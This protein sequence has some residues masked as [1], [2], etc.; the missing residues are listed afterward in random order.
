VIE[1]RTITVLP[2]QLEFLTHPARELVYS[3]S[4]ASGK[5]RCCCMKLLQR[6]SVKGAREG[7]ARKTFNTLRRSTLK[8]LLEPDGALPPVLPEGSYTYN[9]AEQEIKI[10]GGGS[11]LLF[12]CDDPQKL[13]SLNLTGVCVDECVELTEDDW[14][15]L[16]GRIRMQVEGL[17]N[18]LYGACNPSTPSHWLCIRFGL[19]GGHQCQPNCHAIKTSVHDNWFLDADY[20]ADLE[21]LSGIAYKRF[22]LGEWVGSDGLVF[23][24]FTRD[25]VTADMPEEYDRTWIS[26]DEGYQNPTCFLLLGLKDER[27]FV[28]AEWYETKK[29]EAE[30][31]EKA[32]QWNKMYN[33]ECF[34]VDPSSAKLKASMRHEGLDVFDAENNVYDGIMTVANRLNYDG[35]GHP[36]LTVHPSCEKTIMEFESY[37]W[38]VD[39]SDGSYTEKVVKKFDHA[40]D[41]LR[42]GLVWN[43][44]LYARPN[45][46]G[47][48][49]KTELLQA[50]T[51]ETI[52][53]DKRCWDEEHPMWS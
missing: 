27:A 53:I 5:S 33:P 48:E 14:V 41:S 49:T 43:D 44:G 1:E 2:Q 21:T 47:T 15:M 40:M 36:M 37:E 9:K 46:R 16:R 39:K 11:I 20:V 52:E 4:F 22:V 3:G 17:P 13:G 45:I 50:V 32:L 51:T 29:L 7:L 12:G 8:T 34:V 30:V 23:D 24:Q 25:F 28:R 38:K 6:A 10:K 31:V 19:G 18:Q 42:Y 26:V 35:S